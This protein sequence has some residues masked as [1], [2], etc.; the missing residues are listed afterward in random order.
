MALKTFDE[1][2]AELQQQVTAGE[3]DVEPPGAHVDR[4][5][6]G[7]EVEELDVVLR[8]DQHQ[9]LGVLA[10]AVPGLME[11]RRRRLRER[12][13]VGDC[14]AQHLGVPFLTVGQ[15]ESGAP[16]RLGAPLREDL[17]GCYRCA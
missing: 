3:A 2:F 13:L 17:T 11:H 15:K 6:A 7:A 9:L 10:L 4:D 16:N 8:I 1:L 5:V 12:T 14:D